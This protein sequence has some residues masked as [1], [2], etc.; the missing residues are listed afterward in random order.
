MAPKRVKSPNIRLMATSSS[1]VQTQA[2]R[3]TNAVQPVGVDRPGQPA[4][5]LCWGTGPYPGRIASCDPRT[6]YA[7]NPPKVDGNFHN[8]STNPRSPTKNRSIHRQ[9][10][11]P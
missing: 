2:A 6:T 9:L 4:R 8:K 10:L 7:Y 5:K 11:P 3:G 1:A